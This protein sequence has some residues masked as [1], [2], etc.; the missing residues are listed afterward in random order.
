LFASHL[1]AQ[2]KAVFTVDTIS[3][4]VPFTVN[5]SEKSTGNPTQYSWDF[6]NGQTSS[7]RTPVVTA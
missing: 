4:C 2:L 7:V 5:I 1:Q 3:G 6:G